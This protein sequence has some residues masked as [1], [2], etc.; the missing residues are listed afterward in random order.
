MTQPFTT[1]ELHEAMAQWGC[2]C[3]PAALAFA[4]QRRISVDLVPGF[5]VKLYTSPEM[6]IAGLLLQGR[7]WTTITPPARPAS[8]AAD[9]DCGVLFD[10]RPALVR[11][12]W[13]GPWT[14]PGAALKWAYRYTHWVCT[15][16]SGR[17]PM[18]FDINGLSQTYT[19][20]RRSIVPELLRQVGGNG[21]WHPTHV[22]RLLP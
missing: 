14:E 19:G 15:W 18:V 17:T 11:I 6:M 22:W 5:A 4:T 12:Q 3:G 8:V 16:L 7:Q 13:T 20:W 21:G 9:A 2:N 10:R 1:T